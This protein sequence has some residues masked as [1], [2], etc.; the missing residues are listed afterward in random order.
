MKNEYEGIGDGTYRY[1]ADMSIEHG[2]QHDKLMDIIVELQK[3]LQDLKKTV[4][5]GVNDE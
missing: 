3:Q 2:K 1:I 4:D 5:R